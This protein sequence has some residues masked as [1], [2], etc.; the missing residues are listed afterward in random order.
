MRILK[1]DS[2]LRRAGSWMFGRAKWGFGLALT[3]MGIIGSLLGIPDLNRQVRTDV[4][5]VRCWFPV[6]MDATKFTVVMTP[7]V[8]VDARGRVRQTRDGRE[9]ADHLFTRLEANFAELSLPIPMQLRG[10]RDSCAIVGRDRDVRAEAAEALAQTI[11]A[12]LVIYGAILQGATGAQVQPEFYVRYNSFDEASDLVGP[13]EL[14]RPLRVTLPVRAQDLKAVADHPVNVR[15]RVLS[16]VTLGLAAVAVDDH[17]AALAYFGEAEQIPDWSAGAGKE[18]I[19]LLM[20]NAASNLAAIDLDADYVTE[21]MIYYEEALALD[22]D[23]ARA[24]IGLA[25]ATYQQALGDLQTRRGSAVEQDLLD[26]AEIL[27]EIA[28]ETPAPAAAEIEIKAR[29]GLGQIYLVR[30]YL[31]GGDWLARARAQFQLLVDHQATTPVRAQ[32]LIGHAYARL[33]LIAAQ[34]DEDSAAAIPLY[35]EAIPLVTPRWQAVYNLDL[36]DLH[37]RLGDVDTARFHYTEALGIAELH[38]KR[39]LVVQAE[40][41][42]ASLSR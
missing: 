39:D 8:T 2:R 27:Y 33:G 29:F 18:L 35:T 23:F 32:D 30:H 28:L 24:L 10:P 38:G 11:D 40:S 25:G 21:A 15:A 17:A 12:D 41:H 34:I 6:A 19:Y 13:H 26:E 7:L 37:A 22:P 16:L 3:I 31:L 9:L 5:L 20:G 4:P 42:L 14:G 36:G 1:K